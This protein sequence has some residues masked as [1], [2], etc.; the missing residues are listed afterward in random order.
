MKL[1][2]MYLELTEILHIVN[3]VYYCKTCRN[4]FCTHKYN[5]IHSGIICVTCH[6][7]SY[8][9]CI[10]L[11]VYNFVKVIPISI[12]NNGSKYCIIKCKW[13]ARK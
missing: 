1:F 3:Q 2:I 4:I 10:V 8:D 9:L 13:S 11:N 7:K 6:K 12:I 5:C